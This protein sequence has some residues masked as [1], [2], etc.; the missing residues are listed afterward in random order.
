MGRANGTCYLALPMLT[1]LKPGVTGF[2]EPMLFKKIVSN[3]KNTLIVNP[4]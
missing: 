2:V 4:D 3:L 1:G